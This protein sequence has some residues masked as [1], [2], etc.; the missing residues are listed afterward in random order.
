MENIVDYISEFSPEGILSFFFTPEFT[1]ILLFVKIIFIIV[2]AVLVINIFYLI[3]LSSWFSDRY[4]KDWEEFRKFNS[5][6]AENISKK[7]QRID[8]R[9]KTKKETEYKLA[10]LEAEESLIDALKMTGNDG[11][12]LEE[13]LNQ[14]GPDDLS[15]I[16][17]ILQAHKIRNDIVNNPEGKLEFEKAEKA[18]RIFKQAFEELQM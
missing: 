7:W 10:V 11:S 1:G 17:D 16:K 14:A 9:M 18:V 5:I 12:T 6:D 4:A 3:A 8:K 15:D 13:Q 2:S